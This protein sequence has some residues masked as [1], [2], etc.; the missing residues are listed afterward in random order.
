MN[1]AS[2]TSACSQQRVNK[3]STFL[4]YQ[5]APRPTIILTVCSSRPTCLCERS[6]IYIYR[7]PDE[8]IYSALE[9]FFAHFQTSAK[10]DFDNSRIE[11][12]AQIYQRISHTYPI[13]NIPIYSIIQSSN[14]HY[15]LLTEIPQLS[16]AIY[17]ILGQACTYAGCTY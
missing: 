1:T 16:S 4:A 5:S 9:F 2:L 11:A 7:M 14:H 6:I 17:Y 12:S 3:T 8:R 15:L 13:N 10:D